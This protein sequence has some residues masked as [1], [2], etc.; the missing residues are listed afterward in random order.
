[1]GWKEIGEWAKHDSQKKNYL[2]IVC[3]NQVPTQETPP[4]FGWRRD[5]EFQ[6]KTFDEF[7][8]APL[9]TCFKSTH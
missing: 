6:I 8:I 2:F 7:E 5:F 3:K 1:M 9:F 4:P